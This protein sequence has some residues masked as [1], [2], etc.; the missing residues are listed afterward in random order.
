M[1]GKTESSLGSFTSGSAASA[2]LRNVI[3][4]I[5]AMIMVLI[6]NLADTF[7][8]GQTHN[9][10]MVAAV[11][12]AT[13]VFLLFMSIGTLFGMGGTSLI[14][15]ALGSGRK[16][17][18]RK[19][20][21]FCFWAGTAVG[22][23]S[24]VLLMVFSGPVS[25]MLGAS[26]ETYGYTK[27]YLAI[28]SASGVFS[29]ISNC[30]TNIIRAEGKSTIAMGGTL[31]GNLIN[32]VLDPIMIFGLNLG[33]AGAAIATVIGNV[34]GAFYYVIYFLMGKSMLSIRLRDF[35]AKDKICSGV[36]AIGIPAALGN[37]LMSVSQM[38]TNSRMSAYG[39]MAVA[40]YGVS[41]KVLMIVSLAGIGVGQ[42]VQPLLGYCFGAK[43]RERYKS[44]LRF[45]VFFALCLCTGLTVLCYVFA[46]PIV[47]VFLT[48]ADA[49][50]LG[51][52]FSRIM[53]TTA[54]LFGV[55]YVVMNALQAMGAA[56]P[57]LII[58][59]CRQGLIYIPSVFILESLVGMSG[60]AWAQPV[61]DIISLIM[62]ILMY[63][64]TVRKM[65]PGEEE[66]A[67]GASAGAARNT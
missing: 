64:R 50:S 61:A 53:L 29:I 33:I 54:W 37:I 10:Y 25:R 40:A 34:A 62:E 15:R 65:N 23:V 58:S 12:L 27:T 56:T 18:A 14:S 44:S 31:L 32:I 60:L 66:T 63:N 20:S 1:S 13:P 9:D 42:G 16:E 41:A 26:E 11:S 52:R 19:V 46:N 59:L 36:L 21:S 51:V 47:M 39:D 22:I 49:L 38:I 3:P 35:A 2:V 43:N 17:Y 5:A 30:Y 57:S 6:Y 24:S 48:D 45:S 7:F 55:Y 4:A 8:I 28:V 67:E